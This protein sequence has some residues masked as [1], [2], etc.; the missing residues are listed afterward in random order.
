MWRSRDN[1]GEMKLCLVHDRTDLTLQGLC[2]CQGGFV[3]EQEIKV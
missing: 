1:H 3:P 2:R